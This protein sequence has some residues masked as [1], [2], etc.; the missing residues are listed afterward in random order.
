MFAAE[1]HVERGELAHEIAVRCAFNQVLDGLE[2]GLE[3]GAGS[4]Q[5]YADRRHPP[6]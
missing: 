2:G 3:V 5:C 1:K 6:I 4:V